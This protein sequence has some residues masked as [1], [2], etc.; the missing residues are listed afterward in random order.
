MIKQHVCIKHK[1]NCG[2][3]KSGPSCN[4]KPLV[5]FI[6]CNI[7]GVVFTKWHVIFIFKVHNSKTARSSLCNTY[8]SVMWDLDSANI[9]IFLFVWWGKF[10]L[11]KKKLWVSLKD[12][13]DMSSE[14]LEWTAAPL[15]SS[16]G[17]REMLMQFI[18]V[19][20]VSRWNIYYILK[21]MLFNH[22]WFYSL[23]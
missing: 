12:L 3:K 11:L 9:A 13:N 19:I 20:V 18:H 6:I 17:I 15:R 23:F 21:V 16:N 5:Q 8:Q 7:N 22:D 4:F 1:R 10:L 14:L 2:L